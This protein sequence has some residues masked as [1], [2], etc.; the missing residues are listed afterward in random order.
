M[1]FINGLNIAKYHSIL[2]FTEVLRHGYFMIL[3]LLGLPHVLDVLATMLKVTDINPFGIKQFLQS[4][5]ALLNGLLHRV[6]VD[7]GP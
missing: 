7:H 5:G 3:L 4:I 1:P 2:A 6:G